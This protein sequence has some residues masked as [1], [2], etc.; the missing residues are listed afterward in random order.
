[1]VWTVSHDP[2]EFLTAAGGFLRAR[3]DRNTVLLSVSA[4]LVA[5]G[6]DLY[7]ADEPV[8]GWWRAQ[9]DGDVAGAWLWTPPHAVGVSAMPPEAADALPA[10]LAGLDPLPAQVRGE[11]SLAGRVAAGLAG[12]TGTRPARLVAERLYRLAQLSPPHPA[13]PGRARLARAGD[14]D[15]LLEWLGRFEADIGHGAG[16]ANPRRLDAWLADGEI[17]LWEAE[18]RPVSMA[19]LRGLPAET[20]RIGPVY[21]PTELRG[22]GYAA[23]AVTAAARRGLDDGLREILLFADLANPTS[24]AL[25]ARLGFVPVEDCAHFVCRRAAAQA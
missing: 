20:G 7:G 1:M 22:R 17:T 14:R 19:A 2:V 24:N 13:P 21:T 10:L 9:P 5:L 3:P 6:A 11:E 4:S 18:G 16:A 15:L 25:Y 8:F 12:R 23:A